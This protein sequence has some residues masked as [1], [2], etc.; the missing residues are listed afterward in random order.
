MLLASVFDTVLVA[1]GVIQYVGYCLCKLLMIKPVASIK[2]EESNTTG[3]R[4]QERRLTEASIAGSRA[5]APAG[6]WVVLVICIT[7]I[8]ML[9]ESEAANQRRDSNPA[10][11]GIRPKSFVTQIPTSALRK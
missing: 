6:G 10:S 8:A 2:T 7:T 3:R 4:Y 11:E 9:V 5:V 1:A